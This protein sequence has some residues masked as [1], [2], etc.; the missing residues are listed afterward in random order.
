MNLFTLILLCL[1]VLMLLL[2][3]MQFMLYPDG[4]VWNC[5][6]GILATS[7]LHWGG[8]RCGVRCW[9]S[10][11]RGMRKWI[12]HWDNPASVSWWWG[13][14]FPLLTVFWVCYQYRAVMKFVSAFRHCQTVK[15]HL[16]NV[17]SV[18]SVNGKPSIMQLY[19]YL[20]DCLYL[21]YGCQTAINVCM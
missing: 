21:V 3:L 14:A 15:L 12:S 6:E 8:R 7:E 4:V 1:L 19:C 17:E 10:R 16:A 11:Q 2:L 9:Q 5:W 18:R 13:R 20:C